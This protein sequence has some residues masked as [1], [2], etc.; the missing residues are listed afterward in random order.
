MRNKNKYDYPGSAPEINA[1]DWTKTMEG[2][3]EYLHQF[4]RINDILLE[5]VVRTK[6]LSVDEGNVL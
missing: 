5:Y 3:R 1:K 4:H 6:L 2:A